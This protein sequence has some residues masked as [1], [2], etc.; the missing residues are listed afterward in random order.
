MDDNTNNSKVSMSF[1]L[2]L[3]NGESTGDHVH[4]HT[5]S[6]EKFFLNYIVE[7]INLFF[8]S[9]DITDERNQRTFNKNESLFSTQY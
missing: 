6:V 4:M 3:N 1:D 8:I 9:G 7:M 5:L 2:I